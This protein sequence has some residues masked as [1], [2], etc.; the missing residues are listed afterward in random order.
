MA[1]QMEEPEGI[2]SLVNIDCHWPDTTKGKMDGAFMEPSAILVAV[3]HL[4]WAYWSPQ[5]MYRS[6]GSVNLDIK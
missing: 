2:S 5:F 1:S 3:V 6:W 4:V